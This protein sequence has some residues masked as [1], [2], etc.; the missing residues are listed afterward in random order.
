MKTFQFMLV[1]VSNN[2]PYTEIKSVQTRSYF[3]ELIRPINFLKCFR[4]LDSPFPSKK[5]GIF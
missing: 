2:T 3:R 4:T 1:G 5:E